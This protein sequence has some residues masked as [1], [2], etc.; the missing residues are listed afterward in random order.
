[1]VLLSGYPF[2]VYSEKW[3]L[4]WIL[5]LVC[6]W[7]FLD[8]CHK[9]SFALFVGYR[10]GMRYD[11]ADTW[12]VPYYTISFVRGFILPKRFGGTKPGFVS[13]GSLDSAITERRPRPSSL[14]RRFRAI[15]VHQL[16]WVH[17]LF[18]LGCVLGVVMNIVRCFDSGAHIRTAYSAPVLLA[19]GS[20]RW[21]FLLTRIGWPPVFWL[22]QAVS[23]W[24]PIEY[25]L[26]PPEEVNAEDALLL[27]EK[28]GVRYVREE[29][30][31]PK[32]TRLGRISDHFSTLIGVYALVCFAG[33]FYV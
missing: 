28:T 1:M 17:F 14:Y 23:C 30:W 20:E 7:T 4:A 18:I 29:Y 25:F 19:T 27:D 16:V 11:Q 2:L 10:N 5:R 3:Q 9:A 21:V 12:L 32:R 13:S 26:F 31:S 15:F 8:W 6:I 24:I 22:A 33:S